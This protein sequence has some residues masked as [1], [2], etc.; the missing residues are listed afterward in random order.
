MKQL[1]FTLT[2]GMFFCS[3]NAQTNFNGNAQTGFGGPIG[4]S[5][6][7]VNDNGTTISFSLTKGAGDF[8]DALVVYIDSKTGGFANTS[9]F[10]D[11]ADGLRMAISG[12]SGGSM[13]IVANNRSTVNFASGFEAD[14]AISL[15]PACCSFGGVWE[16]ANGGDN[17]LIY[18][19]S[20]NLLP[21][22]A[23]A[24]TYTWSFDKADIGIT[25]SVTFKFVA[26]YLNQGNSFRSNEGF[27]AGL[28]G[29]NV[30]VA[31][32]TFTNFLT[33][34]SSLPV[35]F[36]AVQLN[37]QAGKYLLKWD[38]LEEENIQA[39]QVQ[40]STNGINFVPQ[41]QLAATGSKQYQYTIAQNAFLY[42]RIA[43][44]EKNGLILYSKTV[45]ADLKKAGSI[46]ITANSS[47][48]F[49]KPVGVEPGTYTL[50][51]TNQNG[52]QLAQ[53]KINYAGSA[54]QYQPSIH[55]PRGI[56][57]LTLVGEGTKLSTSFLIQ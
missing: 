9:S 5:V 40:S 52:Q 19:N 14:Y 21:L 17:S 4:S 51:I 3:V 35:K 41:A 15:G 1:L 12:T 39:Y 46:M 6:L 31:A 28:P 33:Y 16:L 24:T 26:T 42:Y 30:G 8:N 55:L 23:N 38:V 53:S 45:K 49:I 13:G 34:S 50:L 48:L 47:R 25:G 43:A 54:F 11:Q 37:Q 18:K 27:G 36:G 7:T 10:N 29:T 22:T 32:A 20:A 44:I 57:L 2:A 56:C